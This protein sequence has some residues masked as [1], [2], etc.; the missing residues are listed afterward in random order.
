MGARLGLSGGAKQLIPPAG[1]VQMQA[2]LQ[3]EG[4]RGI[5]VV[6]ARAPWATVKQESGQPQKG[7]PQGG[8]ARP[9]R[10]LRSQILDGGRKRQDE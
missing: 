1:L 9:C 5:G 10:D 2:L 4:E 8:L 3:N 6:W 7:H